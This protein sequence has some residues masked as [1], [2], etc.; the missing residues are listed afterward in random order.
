MKHTLR[1]IFGIDDDLQAFAEH[2]NSTSFQNLTATFPSGV[3]NGGLAN[4]YGA[5]I[6]GYALSGEQITVT[7]PSQT[8]DWLSIV[9][10]MNWTYRGRALNDVFSTARAR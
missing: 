2:I 3:I 5:L 9:V 4:P 10:T 6:G 8:S 1:T 7:Y